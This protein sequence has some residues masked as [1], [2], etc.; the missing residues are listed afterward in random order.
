MKP[1]ISSCPGVRRKSSPDVRLSPELLSFPDSPSSAGV[2]LGRRQ[3]LALGL[4][5]LGGCA[6]PLIRSQSPE[7]DELLGDGEAQGVP[8]V[9]QLA[10]AQGL[11]YMKVESVGLVTGLHGTGSDPPP[12]SLRQRLMDEMESHETEGPNAVL[13][14]P[15]TS[16]AL[17]RGYLPPG[18]QKGDTFDVEILLPHRSE[19]TSLR[20]G[21]LMQSR[22]R[23]VE[24]LGG[25]ALTGHVI[26]LAGGPVLVDA[27]FKSD[28]EPADELRGRVLAGGIARDSRPLGLTV[29]RDSRSVMTATL[30]SSAINN[31]FHVFQRGTKKGVADPKNDTYIELAAHP[32]Y[33]HNLVRYMAVVRN[34]PME[35]T[36]AQH[37]AWLALLER[38]L[39][40]P[41]SAALAALRLEAV[42]DDA[43]RILRAGA[44]SN[45]AEVRLYS[46]EALAYLDDLAAVKPLADAARNEP[47]FRWH[48]LTALS[49]MSHVEASEALSDLLHVTSAETRY[50]AFRAMRAR[51]PDD[52]MLMGEILGDGFH[53]HVIPTTGEGMVHFCRLR[54]REAALFGTDEHLLTPCVLFAGPEIMVRG[55]D[56]GNVKVSR[57]TPGAKDRHAS[58]SSRI[59]DVIRAIVEVGGGYTEVFAALQQASQERRLSCRLVVDALP[60][61]A[62]TYRRDD[63]HR[64]D[65]PSGESKGWLPVA[66]P[67]PDLFAVPD[68][69]ESSGRSSHSDGG[70][71]LADGHAIRDEFSDSDG[72]TAP[73]GGLLGRMTRWLFR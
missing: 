10:G 2:Q 27:V 33:R 38:Q 54:R 41:T 37:V 24:I 26:A 66:N 5:L 53:F 63:E 22:M 57:F 48:A 42:G 31:R 29:R 56:E 39:A 23:R 32:R 67:L 6:S 14:S 11:N 21:W 13:A 34:I 55:I 61:R 19:T 8:L 69:Q 59:S 64:Q 65:S 7:I 12:S 36:P 18:V 20:Y 17:V 50:G 40:E 51:S 9:G 60:S 58:C 28:A 49:A 52:P 71:S 25:T 15:A 3:V 70:E 68:G 73:E 30:I 16:M 62:R 47:A 43:V 46:A 45:D 44:Q 35:S 72:D 1:R 4:A